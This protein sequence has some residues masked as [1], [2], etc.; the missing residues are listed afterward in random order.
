MGSVVSLNFYVCSPP[1][2]FQIKFRWNYKRR[3]AVRDCN[4]TAHCRRVY[5]NKLLR[6]TGM[7]SRI[8]VTSGTRVMRLYT[9]KETTKTENQLHYLSV[10]RS[11]F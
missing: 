10:T 2:K 3:A 4:S 1:K 7:W 6:R 11:A 9:E 8:V 5:Q